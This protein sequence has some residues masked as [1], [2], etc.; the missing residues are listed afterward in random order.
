MIV[1]Y[2]SKNRQKLTNFNDTNHNLERTFKNNRIFNLVAKSSLILI[3]SILLINFLIFSHYFSK[4]EALETTSS[5]NTINKSKLQELKTRVEKKEEL[6]NTLVSAANSKSSYYLDI[7]AQSI[8]STILLDEIQY[9]PLTKPVRASKPIVLNSDI[10]SIAGTTVNG[11][12]FSLWIENLEKLKW[13]T[14][15]KTYSYDYSTK[16]TSSF[17]ININTLKNEK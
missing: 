13:V 9:Q 14:S 4:V 11:S 1:N 5:A 6:V 8:P 10:I 16:N 2:V 15:V 12:D 17:S 3:L 7:I